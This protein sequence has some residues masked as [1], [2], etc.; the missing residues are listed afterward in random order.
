MPKSFNVCCAGCRI[1]KVKCERA[2]GDAACV[3][4]TKLGIICVLE[5]RRSKWDRVVPKNQ[6][7][8]PNIIN[9]PVYAELVGRI[10]QLSAA[11]T[12]LSAVNTGLVE[13]LSQMLELALATDGGEAL[14]WT[15]SLAHAHGVPPSRLGLTSRRIAAAAAPQP[16]PPPPLQPFL[17]A[18]LPFGAPAMAPGVGSS[19][20][21]AVGFAATAATV[22]AAAALP[23]APLPMA[24]AVPAPPPAASLPPELAGHLAG[25]V[26]ARAARRNTARLASP[27]APPPSPAWRFQGAQAAPTRRSSSEACG[28]LSGSPR[29]A[30][31]RRGGCFGGTVSMPSPRRL[32]GSRRTGARPGL[33][34]RRRASTHGGAAG[35]TGPSTL[36]EDRAPSAS[37]DRPKAR[38]APYAPQSAA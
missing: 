10:M 30:P 34:I 29:A 13:L 21:H 8:P 1:A 16:M 15:I 6:Q 11:N 27:A 19:A 14:A 33:P 9:D 28:G 3:R 22:T 5:E 26:P 38:A 2:E 17:A 35:G 31:Q 23:V 37:S 7:P 36:P 32:R 4:C 12:G 25:P 24:M 18:A 20:Q